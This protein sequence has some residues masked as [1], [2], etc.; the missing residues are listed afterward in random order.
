[1]Q[2]QIITGLAALVAAGGLAA[3]A[4]SSTSMPS[5]PS[6]SQQASLDAFA[7]SA[8]S[9]DAEQPLVTAESLR[10]SGVYIGCASYRKGADEELIGEIEEYLMQLHGN[11][12]NALARWASGST[13]D[14]ITLTWS[15]I[16]DGVTL[17]GQLIHP[18]EPSNPNIINQRLAQIFGSTEQGLNRIRLVFDKWEDISGVDYQE[19]SDNGGAFGLAGQ[20]NGQSGRGDIRIGMKSFNGLFNGILAYNLFPYQGGNPN[21]AQGEMVL[22]ADESG[23]FSIPNSNYLLFRN[24][25]AHEHGHGL[26]F[27]HVCPQNNTKLMEPAAS[28]SFDGPQHDDVRAIQRN[29]GDQYEPNDSRNSPFELGTLVNGFSR[30]AT[31]ASIDRTGDIDHYNVQVTPNSMLSVTVQPIGFTYQDWDQLSNGQC[32]SSGSTVNSLRIHDLKVRILDPDGTILVD[33]DDVGLGQTE[34]IEDFVLP[35]GDEF[36]VRVAGSNSAVPQLYTVT[37]LAEDAPVTDVE[38][39]DFNVIRG[40]LLGGNLNSLTENDNNNLRVNSVF[41]FLSSEPNVQETEVEAESPIT[42]VSTLS[43]ATRVRLNNPGGSGQVRIRNWDNNNLITFMNY[44][45][46]TTEQEFTSGNISNPNRF[47][48][49]SDGAIEVR[50]KHVVVATFS[51]SGF[52]SFTDEVR[53]EVTN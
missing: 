21:Q 22:N 5:A 3:L 10:E 49:N 16:P 43:F 14:P 26:G 17:P 12:F 51:L 23:F 31:E 53:F 4:T 46:T 42:T 34:T 48:R 27:A 35:P 11:N 9:P 13:G 52:I 25:I 2:N 24:V 38:L 33:V 37:V 28:G 44:S 20:F 30:A 18:Q 45:P 32:A 15:I 29:Y 6:A 7:G 40:S 47:V 8:V 36:V 50:I 1:M 39:T 19:V 41:G